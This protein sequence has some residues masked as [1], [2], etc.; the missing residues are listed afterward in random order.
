MTHH[1]SFFTFIIQTSSFSEDAMSEQIVKDAEHRMEVAVETLRHEL[2]TIRTGRA[3]PALLDRVMVEYYGQSMPLNQVGTVTVPESRSLMITPWDK[4]ALGAIEKALQKSDLGLTPNNDGVNI[5]LNIPPL[6]EQR[7][8]ELIKQVHKMVEDHK[9]AARNVR[10]DANDHLKRAE[11]A[12]E[13]SE[14]E[15]RRFQ[16]RIQKVTDRFIAEM[17]KIQAAKEEELLEV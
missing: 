5:R 17:D 7:R 10:R 8:K 6:T 1:S 13:I 15:N 12:G 2:A 14:D 11:K 4:A 9:V 3:S 16:D